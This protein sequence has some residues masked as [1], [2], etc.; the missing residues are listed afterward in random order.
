VR[1]LFIN[2]LAELGGAERS[3]LDLIRSLRET[4]EFA[5]VTVC[6]FSPGPLLDVVRSMGCQA[7]LVPLPA[8]LARLGDSAA[9]N[10][11]RPWTVLRGVFATLARGPAF[12]CRLR[13]EIDRVG[14]DIV[15]T[16]GF[17]SHLFGA[18]VR[19][20]RTRLVWHLRDFVRS[21]PFLR[22]VLPLAA[23]RADL[24]IAISEAVAVDARALLPVPVVTLL[25]AIDTS[26][27]A[28]GVVTPLDLDRAAGLSPASSPVTR[29]GL[30]ATYAWWK[31]HEV[32]FRAASRLRGLPIRFYIIGGSLYARP[33]SQR[34][35]AELRALISQLGLTGTTGLVPFQSDP[36]PAYLALDIVVHASTAPEPFGRTIAEA[37][38]CGR[39]VIASATGG[40][41]EQIEDGRTGLLVAPNDPE[42]LAQRIASL[43]E[44]PERR[45]SL[46]SA[47]RASAVSSLDSKRL[48]PATLAWYREICQAPRH[49]QTR[50]RHLRT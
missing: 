22:F 29:V 30:V 20:R 8:A 3:L 1:I 6:V 11:T 27:F 45:T 15:H 19:S 24:A 21:R 33:G 46:G 4:S 49:D 9:D 42:A 50:P 47:A 5:E 43:H 44:S 26:H 10:S 40:T 14:P 23:R 38:S 17:K 34:T 2:P 13:R 32:F 16:N 7:L 41:G 31:G 28:P 37:M 25:N 48:G 18:L 35:S 36:R 12:V 39:S